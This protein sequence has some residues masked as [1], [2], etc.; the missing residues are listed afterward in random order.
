[1]TL[2]LLIEITLKASLIAAAGLGLVHLLKRLPAARRAAIAHLSLLAVVL[3][4]VLVIF[5]PNLEIAGF[6]SQSVPAPAAVEPVAASGAAEAAAAR[7][8]TIPPPAGP[9]IGDLVVVG[10]AAGAVLLGLGLL[11]GLVRLFRLQREASVLTDQDWLCALARAQHRMGV[12]QGTALLRSERLAS[13]V[14]WGLLR[15]T[16]VLS[17]AALD[18]PERAEAIV[19]HELAHVVRMDWANLLV[20]RVATAMLWFNPLVWLLARQAHELREE[21]ADDVVLRGEVDGPDYAS[22]LVAFA[23][24][25]GGAAPLA[26]HGVAP[27]KGSLRRRLER[28]LDGQ[29]RREPAG[30]AWIMGCALGVATLAIPLAAFTPVDRAG[31]P[32]PSTMFGVPAPWLRAEVAEPRSD[33]VEPPPGSAAEAAAEPE[34]LALAVASGSASPRPSGGQ[35]QAQAP[36]RL[37]PETLSSLALHGVTPEWIARLEPELP[38]IRRASADELLGL[39]IHRVTPEWVRGLR[40]VGYGSLSPDEL[41]SLAAHRVNPEYIRELASAGYRDLTVDQLIGLRIGGVDAGY[42]RRMEA[43]GLRVDPDAPPRPGRRRSPAPPP[44]PAGAPLPP[45]PPPPLPAA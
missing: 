38:W 16:I 13:P 12:K 1:M 34:P 19:A 29:A 21:A 5:G 31:P 9:D 7:G 43:Q 20:A 45:T 39:A 27:G 3:T 36:A 44:S 23:R 14:S 40:E 6:W 2:D 4:P 35:A 41:T 18:T 28:V 37:S 30:A 26:A 42:I 8:L 33:N 15:P 25:G 10:W 22:L 32:A 11:L 17:P 24:R